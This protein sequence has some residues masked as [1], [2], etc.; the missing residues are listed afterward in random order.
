M[1]L[2]IILPR[3]LSGLQNLPP[4]N[5]LWKHLLNCFTSLTEALPQ[6]MTSSELPWG[7]ACHGPLPLSFPAPNRRPNLAGLDPKQRATGRAT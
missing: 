3:A 7:M 5:D 6:T 4:Q 1:C 2:G